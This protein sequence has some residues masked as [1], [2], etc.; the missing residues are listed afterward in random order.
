MRELAVLSFV[1]LDG[2]MQAPSAPEEDTS[3][4]FA[5]GGWAAPYWE[6][7]MPEVARTAMSAPYDIL[8]GRKTYDIFAS[9]W[10]TAPKSDVAEIL[11]SARKHVATS[12]SNELS[13]ENSYALTGDI[14]EGVRNLKSD[15]GPLLQVHGSA[16]LIQTLQANDLIDEFR[17]WTFPVVVGSGKRLFGENSAFMCYALHDFRVLDNGVTQ[18]M[19]RRA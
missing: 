12:S 1:T 19:F 13:W 5:R 15:V 3:G 16:R 11:N 18:Q 8:F 4:G 14:V 9:H 17:I 2:V 6:E 7:V 10:P